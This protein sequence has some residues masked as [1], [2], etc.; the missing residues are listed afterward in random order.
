MFCSLLFLFLNTKRV[1]SCSRSV[2]FI[3]TSQRSPF[4]FNGKKALGIFFI[5]NAGVS[6]CV[7]VAIS[8]KAQPNR[9]HSNV[10]EQTTTTIPP[11][12]LREK[13]RKWKLYAVWLSVLFEGVKQVYL[14]R[15]NVQ[16]QRA[17]GEKKG[18]KKELGPDK[19]QHNLTMLFPIIFHKSK[20][21]C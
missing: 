19:A 20:W 3:R 4:S 11:P 10:H 9:H 1:R 13:K 12:A 8:S 14:R 2:S 7:H 18:I 16:I 17:T 6:L 15:R 5:N 21:C